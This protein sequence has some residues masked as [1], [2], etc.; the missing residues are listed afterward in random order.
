[1]TTLNQ[2]DF[3]YIKDLMARGNMTADQA[4]VE[5]VKMARVRVI[6]GSM[7]A[8]VRKA[9][10]IAVK[11]GELNHKVKSGK[12][13]EVYYHPNFEHLANGERSRIERET[14][15]ALLSVCC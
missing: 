6:I 15:N 13:P 7:P 2:N 1:M 8:S 10:N 3:E 14:L 12:K 4:N 9:L 5:M 11:T